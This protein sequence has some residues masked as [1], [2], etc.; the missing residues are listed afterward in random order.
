MKVITSNNSYNGKNK[1]NI[2]SITGNPVFSIDV[3]DMEELY[4][5]DA[6]INKIKQK[7]FVKFVK[8]FVKFKSFWI[9]LLSN[10]YIVVTCECEHNTFCHR[11]FFAEFLN[12][13]YIGEFNIDKEA[14]EYIIEKHK[15]I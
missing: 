7:Y 10:E 13:E 12:E 5:T 4:K 2:S 11:K 1:I 3:N 14:T 8:S 6:N 15:T 9:N